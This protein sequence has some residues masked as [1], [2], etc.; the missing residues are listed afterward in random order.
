MSVHITGP[1]AVG[2]S[3]ALAIAL[4]LE[5]RRALQY[6]LGSGPTRNVIRTTHVGLPNQTAGPRGM[7]ESNIRA[8]RGKNPPDG[9]FRF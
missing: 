6:L 8:L 7:A 9:G 4:D 5:A 2:K 1:I 3:M